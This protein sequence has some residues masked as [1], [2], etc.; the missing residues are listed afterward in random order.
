[1]ITSRLKRNGYFCAVNALNHQWMMRGTAYPA[2][3]RKYWKAVAAVFFA[4]YDSFSRLPLHSFEAVFL[5]LA[6]SRRYCEE[7][8]FVN[9]CNIPHVV[10]V[11]SVCEN[12]DLVNH[13]NII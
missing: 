4:F 1:M 9:I 5:C 10:S 8:S 6:G 11:A 2:T 12:A 13:D 7:Q 3:L